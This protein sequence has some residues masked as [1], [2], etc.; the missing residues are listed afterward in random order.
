[1]YLAWFRWPP[2][3]GAFATEKRLG[4]WVVLVREFPMIAE[5][6]DQ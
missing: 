2:S 6:I 4:G 3:D 5:S 1:V